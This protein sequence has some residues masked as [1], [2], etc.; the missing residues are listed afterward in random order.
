M[1]KLL[2]LTALFLGII[3]T[4]YAIE[5]IEDVAVTDGPGGLARDGNVIRVQNPGRD[6]VVLD[7]LEV[8]ED[9]NWQTVVG[10]VTGIW[11]VHLH[12]FGVTSCLVEK[13]DGS[14]IL[15]NDCT[16]HKQGIEFDTTSATFPQHTSI[17]LPFDSTFVSISSTTVI[18]SDS[19]TTNEELKTRV[20]VGRVQQTKTGGLSIIDLR[21]VISENDRI[22]ATYTRELFGPAV[23]IDGGLV[24]TE[25]DVDRT[26]NLST[27][28]FGDERRQIHEVQAFGSL[29]GITVFT[30]SPDPFGRLTTIR[31]LLT[32]DNVNYND[33]VTGGLVPAQNNNKWVYMDLVASPAGGVV[34]GVD[35]GR[36]PTFFLIY[37]TGEFNSALEA[38]SAPV[39]LAGFALAKPKLLNLW[40]LL[41]RKN[42]TNIEETFDL[43]PFFGQPAGAP[44]AVPAAIDLQGAY[45]NSANSNIPEIKTNDQNEA[46]TILY[47]G[48]DGNAFEV[49]KDEVSP[50]V[51][52]VT[53]SMVLVNGVE[54][55][56]DVESLQY[57]QLE[58]RYPSGTNGGTSLTATFNIRKPST[59]VADEGN[60]A[61]YSTTTNEIILQPGTY[62]D[63][64]I[65]SSARATTAGHQARLRDNSRGLTV[66]NGSSEYLDSAENAT[67][68]SFGFRTFTTSVTRVYQLQHYTGAGRDTT[69]LGQLSSSGE[70]EIY[71]GIK[72]QVGG[73]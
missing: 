18:V 68:H 31:G 62:N 46:L 19:F 10:V 48:T 20:P 33:R 41:L 47:E 21:P 40:R 28:N 2:L 8:S 27:G 13:R 58:E 36:D 6:I 67:T 49:L 1:R 29:T 42:Q 54:I 7:G 61:T 45:D 65:W 57:L 43:R 30:V 23:G 37:G 5:G 50:P 34:D 3:T 71:S 4:A 72:C 11:G 35:S 64:I 56:G 22:T 12:E 14:S 26:I 38:R 32:V 52:E 59:E 17:I 44:A 9:S 63:C 53:T 25:A 69:G 51:F 66:I 55:G 73:I 70:P 16:S 39:D 15:F 24:A 60:F